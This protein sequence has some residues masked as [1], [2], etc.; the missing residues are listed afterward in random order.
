[1]MRRFWRFLLL[2]SLVGHLAGVAVAEEYDLQNGDRVKGQ[3]ASATEEGLVVAL[4]VGGFSPRVSW[5]KLTQESLK[6]L[7]KDPRAK[8]FAEP[9]IDIPMEIKAR[10]SVKKKKDIPIRPATRV[11]RP[12][13]T[14]SLV[15]AITTPA[16]LGLLAI[17]YA[18]N[19]FAA[20]EIAAYRRRPIAIV[21]GTSALLPILG[22]ILF[23]SLPTHA[24]AE[25][26]AA[27]GPEEET[28][29]AGGAVPTGAEAA[30]SHLNVARPAKA[31]VE[32]TL[33]PAVYKRGEFTLNRRFF[34][35][36]FAGYFRV[37]LGEAE[38]KYIIIIRLARDEYTVRRI[39]RITANDMHLMLVKSG[40]EVTVSFNDITQVEL[41]P[42]G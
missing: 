20:Y 19:L 7:A 26:E 24:A 36:K 37:V 14:P 23:I 6:K 4:D 3:I 15:A 2:L 42:A 30:S 1:M 9:F 32:T 29:E 16:G 22:P 38:K 8:E 39:S 5:A 25:V 12:A 40:E 35:T 21:C 11:E 10:Q 17:L 34:E 18:A 41:R 27:G 13:E 28:M 31:A 33:Q